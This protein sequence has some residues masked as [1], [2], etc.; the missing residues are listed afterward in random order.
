MGV[1]VVGVVVAVVVA[2]VAVI[3]GEVVGGIVASGLQVCPTSLSLAFSVKRQTIKALVLLVKVH[4]NIIKVNIFYYEK[5]S[6][7]RPVSD[8]YSNTNAYEW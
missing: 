8:N 1:V 7:K 4:R 5:I 3:G 2:V 6:Y